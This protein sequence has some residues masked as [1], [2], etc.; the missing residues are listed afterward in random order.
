MLSEHEI[1]E[2]LACLTAA[3]DRLSSDHAGLEACVDIAERFEALRQQYRQQPASL[4]SWVSRLAELRRR[5]DQLL[6]M[7]LSQI[8]DRFHQ[9]GEQI[10]LAER[11]KACWRDQLI[12]IASESRR[13]QLDGNSAVVRIRSVMSRTVP[14]AGSLQRQQ[15]EAILRESGC[16]EQVSQLSRPKLDRAMK[17]SLLAKPQADEVERIC[18]VSQI[19]QVSC[20]AR[21]V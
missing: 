5:F 21:T 7:R 6:G 2:H 4:A 10:R 9:I 15:L 13:D 3:L 1:G 18:P 14:P 20:R 12:R 8:V 11:E 16:W 19:H 17:N